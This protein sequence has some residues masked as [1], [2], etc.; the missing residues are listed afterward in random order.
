M[1]HEKLS[2][3]GGAS[4]LTQRRALLLG[5]CAAAL[6]P[7]A[8]M[9]LWWNRFTG[10]SDGVFLMYGQQV[11]AGRVPYRDFYLS[12]PPLTVL[13]TAVLIKVFGSLLVV[14]RLLAVLERTCLSAALFCWLASAFRLR[15]ALLGTV[16][17]MVVVCGD[18]SDQLNSYNH[19]S[20]FL[21]VAAGICATWLLRQAPSRRRPAAFC[22]GLFCGL[23]ML[24]KQTTGS[25]I[26]L[27]LFAVILLSYEP[28]GT[29]ASLASVA[30]MFSAGWALPIA[31]VGVWL[32]HAGALASA[33]ETIFGK[34]ASSKGPLAAVLTRPIRGPLL[35]GIHTES[36]LAALFL[37]AGA[38]L[39]LRGPEARP[40]LAPALSKALAV[41][42]L[43]VAA[44]EAYRGSLFDIEAFGIFLGLF[45][46]FALSASFLLRRCVGPLDASQKRM[47]VFSATSF[48]V[49]Y[50][51]SL[52]WTVYQAMAVPALAFLMCFTLAQTDRTG[53]R[54]WLRLGVTAGTLMM[55]VVAVFLK[56]ALPFW[57]MSW[58][59]PPVWKATAI[60]HL[61]GLRGMRLSPATLDTVE[62]ATAA[63]RAACAPGERLFAYPYLPLLHVLSDRPPA[64]FSYTPWFD[65]TPDYVAEQDA[66]L[67][68]G[69]PPCAIAY[70]ELLPEMTA[71]G[72]RLFRGKA[73]S[74]QRAIVRSIESL[75]KSYRVLFVR[76]ISGIGKFTIYGHPTAPTP[77]ATQLPQ[78][79]VNTNLR[80]GKHSPSLWAAIGTDSSNAA[81]P[82]EPGVADR[83]A[84]NVNKIEMGCWLAPAGSCK[85]LLAPYHS[86]ENKPFKCNLPLRIAGHLHPPMPP[87]SFGPQAPHAKLRTFLGFS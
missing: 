37:L 16:V 10:L 60:P 23:A 87:L 54:H 64:T 86:H 30:A 24:T 17:S 52:S 61:S 15:D 78:P 13:K 45:L 56:L 40:R 82:G 9:S 74:G 84:A 36:W 59:E 1:E 21:S 46:A 50:M 4:W 26:S 3:T 53:L 12:I 48:A 80:L 8:Y 2:I 19:D 67:L 6:L 18:V 72:E 43:G 71:G 25:G 69:R 42:C 47:W 62:T 51:L 63:I 44:Y 5:A 55:I 73:N 14:P 65:V 33:I 70:L 75:A 57:W 31:A 7:L 68:L 85:I 29:E 49:A 28:S 81:A 32:F 20:V 83:N 39:L 38:W 22:C 41:T 11:L 27:T 79:L 77:P 66:G 58:M 35:D 34:G 76:E